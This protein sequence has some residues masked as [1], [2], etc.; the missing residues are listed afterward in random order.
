MRLYL[1]G[2]FVVAQ[3][4]CRLTT[5][6]AFAHLL[7]SIPDI[8]KGEVTSARRIIMVSLLSNDGHYTRTIRGVKTKE[9][10]RKWA[11]SATEPGAH[12]GEAGIIAMR[13]Y[14]SSIKS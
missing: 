10:K 2:C 11:A 8:L 7:N 13:G 4:D 5:I 3:V 14:Y 6:Q 9:G 12:I 1:V